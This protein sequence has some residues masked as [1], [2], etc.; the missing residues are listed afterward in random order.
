M[1]P[2][3]KLIDPL[4][5]PTWDFGGF[6]FILQANRMATIIFRPLPSKIVHTNFVSEYHGVCLGDVVCDETREFCRDGR[7]TIGLGNM[8]LRVCARKSLLKEHR[9]LNIH[10]FGNICQYTNKTRGIATRVKIGSCYLPSIIRGLI[11]MVNNMRG[12]V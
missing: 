9:R 7:E 10:Y 4:E 11:L 1:D 8:L 3:L 5:D 2:R 6:I 12:Y